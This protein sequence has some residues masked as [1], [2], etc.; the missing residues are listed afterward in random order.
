[1]FSHQTMF[2][3]VSPLSKTSTYLVTKQCLIL[4][5]SRGGLPRKQDGDARLN[6]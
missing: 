2:D 3:I 1:M 5:D 6:F 4:F